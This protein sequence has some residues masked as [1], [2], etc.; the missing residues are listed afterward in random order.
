MSTVL[1]LW[2]RFPVVIRAVLMG[3]VLSAAGTIPWAVLVSA[4][5]RHLSAVPWAVPPTA[6]YLYL[7]WR[8]VRGA[9]WPRSTAEARRTNCRANRLPEDVW[10]IALF[11]G[12][13]GLV[14]VL[15]LQGVMSRLV[16]LTEQQDLDVSQ[17][18]LL[19][20]LLWVLM[21]SLVAGV[22]E[23]ASFRATCR[24]RSSGAT[25]R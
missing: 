2:R 10:G 7:F 21:G 25:G 23:E 15:L 9:G 20:V 14:A 13:L 18:P 17:Y 24:G 8:H 3:L 4:N 16:T 1:V 12:V 22:V 11:A 19:T 6:L 5:S